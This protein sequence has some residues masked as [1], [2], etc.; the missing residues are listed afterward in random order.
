MKAVA[1]SPAVQQI[2]A[3]LTARADA[4]AREAQHAP[5]ADVRAAAEE[6][7]RALREFVRCTGID[8]NDLPAWTSNIT[9]WRA[10]ATLAGPVVTT[11]A[12]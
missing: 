8:L 11:Q 9:V 10:I 3:D 6:Q 1:T 4:L 12:G 5:S 2:I 7:L